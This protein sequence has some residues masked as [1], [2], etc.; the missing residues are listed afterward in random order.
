MINF[1][2]DTKKQH[3]QLFETGQKWAETAGD[4]HLKEKY[5]TG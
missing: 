4:H 5:G 2:Q 1:G 3:L